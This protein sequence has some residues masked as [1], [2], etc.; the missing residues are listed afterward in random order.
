MGVAL[1]EHFTPGEPRKRHGVLYVGRLVEK[2]GV[3]DL[4]ALGRH[5]HQDPARRAIDRVGAHD[6]GRDA[7]RHLMRPADRQS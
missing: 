5:L 2:K 4:I 7:D 6:V 1:A 3:G